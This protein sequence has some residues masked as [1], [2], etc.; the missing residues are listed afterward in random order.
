LDLIEKIKV[1]EQEKNC[2]QE[3]HKQ[4][5]DRKAK[6]NR[7]LY[8]AKQAPLI[9]LIT[10]INIPLFFEI[11]QRHDVLIDFEPLLKIIEEPFCLSDA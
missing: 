8:N 10:D 11:Q 1:L 9:P 6:L 7:A 4:L 3:Q 2:L 5:E